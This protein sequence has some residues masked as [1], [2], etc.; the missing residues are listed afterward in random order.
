MTALRNDIA[1]AINRH[2]A[3]K[4]SNT[5][6]YILAEYLADC[7]A[8]FDRAMQARQKWYGKAGSALDA[9]GAATKEERHE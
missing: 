7:L 6:D 1:A 5:P 3:E 9:L 4:G 8:A 2:R